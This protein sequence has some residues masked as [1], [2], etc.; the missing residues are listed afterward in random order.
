MSNTIKLKNYSD[1][2]E[3]Y[4]STAVAITP[5]HLIQ[6]TSAGLVEKHSTANGFVLPMFA[7]E[8]ELQ[9]NGIDDAYA[10]SSKI[11][12]WVPGRGD[13]VNAILADEENVAIG[14][15]LC[16]NAAG[17]LKKLDA[18]TSAGD[19]PNPIGI[20]LAALNLSSSSAAAVADTRIAVRII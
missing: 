14:N 2:F 19:V 1:V 5:G 9:G 6:V 10:I 3:E 4:T 11:Q 18:T 20:A 17:E 16:S 15:F 8:D 7:I 12:C 13:I